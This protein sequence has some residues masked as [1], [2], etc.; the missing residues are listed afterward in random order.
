MR[1][2][3]LDGWTRRTGTSREIDHLDAIE[4][5]DRMPDMSTLTT[6]QNWLAHRHVGSQVDA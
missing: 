2:H 5:V 3:S 6:V 1:G 4:F